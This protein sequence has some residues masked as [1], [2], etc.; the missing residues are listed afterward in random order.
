VLSLVDPA[1]NYAPAREEIVK[2][3]GI[4]N[5]IDSTDQ[6]AN[7]N[8]A[9]LVGWQF[10]ASS[11][12]NQPNTVNVTLVVPPVSEGTVWLQFAY[13]NKGLGTYVN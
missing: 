13:V 12:Q 9:M 8:K 6:A 2:I 1:T 5:N 4:R 3:E 7:I 10:V 11:S